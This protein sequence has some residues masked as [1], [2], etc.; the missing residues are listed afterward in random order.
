M[1]Q[2]GDFVQAVETESFCGDRTV[3]IAAEDPA[4]EVALVPFPGDHMRMIPVPP[5]DTTGPRR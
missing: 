1:R 4:A 3:W 2:I 5:A